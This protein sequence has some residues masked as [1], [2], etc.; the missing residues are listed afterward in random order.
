MIPV[1]FRRLAVLAGLAAS[2]SLVSPAL[3][4]PSY[5]IAMYGD[6][7]LPADFTHLPYTNAQAP[8]G[9]TVVFGEGGTFDL[10]NPFI[11]KGDAP[12]WMSP[13]TMESLM[14]RSYDEPF[15]LYGKL[16]ESI[17]TDPARS[18]VEF[19]LRPNAK[20]S[21]GNPVTV[22]DV[23]WSFK[24][25]GTEGS[26]RYAGAW[27]KIAKAEQT[28][29]RS[30]RFTFTTVDREM[31]LILGLRP[32][33]EKAQWQGKDFTASSLTPPIGSG[34]YV[35]DSFSPGSYVTFKKNP[36]WWGKDLPFNRGMWNF[37]K[38]KFIYFN[39]G[40]V[41]F[42]AFKAGDTMM[43]RESNP[44]KWKTNYDFP[45]VKSGEVV[46]EEIPN[47]RP[48]G[49]QGLVM[50]TRRPIFA[51]WRVRQAMIDAFDFQQVNKTLNDNAYPRITSYFSNSEL[52]AD[53]THPAPPA[54]AALLAPYKDTLLPGV[55]SG[56]SLPVSDGTE[57]NR[58]NLRNAARLL[59]EAGWTV[60][61][62]VLKNA[63]G[64]PFSFEILLVN[65]EE[66][67]IAAANIYVES[68]KRLGIEAHV[69]TVD[70]AQYHQRTTTYD[71]DMTHY[72]RGLSLS[73]GN[74]Q[75]LYWGSA[76]V[77]TPD[78]GNWM[79]M[80]QPAAEAMIKTMLS[81]HSHADFVA[82]VHALDRI[83]TAGRYIVP[84]WYAP[85]SRMAHAAV[86]HHPARIP[87]Y[88][89]WIGFMPD[90]WWYQK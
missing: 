62:G 20:F 64:K 19:T 46:K 61:D 2:L 58:G 30:V 39:S 88:G 10:F 87:I 34:P 41:V 73:P 4:N 56:Y 11:V 16:A 84:F 51:D 17:D 3:A 59:A 48:S 69:T 63:E 44:V 90:V 50:N 12:Y 60:Q 14:G 75:Y 83:L 72:R 6:P 26:P 78:T 40:S 5:G 65:G 70:G 68:L 31:P 23:L 81:A 79:G 55:L 18:Y 71:F 13:L 54:V 82:A 49:I 43:Y 86:L 27:K 57:A 33:L 42:Q 28:G 24:T 25:L 74:E 35:V 8:K 15:T 77:K 52:G 76:G 85:A 53:I 21:D 32:I 38:I 66:D 89:D 22:E 47:K 1:Y 67:Y 7:A 80:D 37:D 9:G 29:P 45:A 36:D